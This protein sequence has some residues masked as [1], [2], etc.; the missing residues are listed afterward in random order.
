MVEA[1]S[2]N[3]EEWPAVKLTALMKQVDAA[4]AES[5]YLFIWDKQ[6]NVATFFGYQQHLTSVAPMVVKAALGQIEKSEIPETIRKDL[7]HTMRS[8]SKMLMDLDKSGKGMGEY[9]EANVF[10]PDLVFNRAEWTQ[11]DNYIKFV[12]ES[13]N[14]GIGGLN[15]GHYIASDDWNLNIRVAHE[16]AA[17]VVAIYDS[18]PNKDQ[19]KCIT[20]KP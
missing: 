15:P 2:T 14:H 20:I 7:V 16:D 11:K 17:D 5:K 13:E 19:L 3:P 6:G 8:G 18:I 9:A 10:H 4:Q 12:K 1:S